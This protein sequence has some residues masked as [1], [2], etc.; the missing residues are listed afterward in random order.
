V[1]H[2]FRLFDNGGR[3][4]DRYTLIDARPYAHGERGAWRAYLAMNECPT[5]PQ[6]GIGLTGDLDARSWAACVSRR[7]RHL[8]RRI[9]VSDLPDE[10]RSVA[11]GWIA[12]MSIDTER[13]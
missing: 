13:D 4:A 5:H 7:F 12:T 11:E 10:A 6:R 2:R 9:A 8:G 3:S 1:P